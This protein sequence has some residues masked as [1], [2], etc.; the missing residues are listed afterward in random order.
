MSPR[1]MKKVGSCQQFIPS[2]CSMDDISYSKLS[3]QEVHKIAILDIRILN[4]DRNAANLLCRRKPEQPDT[5]ELIP[6]DH[7]YCLRTA[8]DICSFDWCWLDWPQLKQ[9][10]SQKTKEYILNLDI[11]KD[12]RMLKE[13]LEIPNGALDY[14]RASNQLLQN[15][16]KAGKTLYEIA[17]L[18]CR[19]DHLGERPSKLES[20]LSTAADIA[21]SAV[22]NGR[23]HHA[24]ASRALEQQLTPNNG[25]LA[26]RSF[27]KGVNGNIGRRNSTSMSIFKSASSVNFTSFVSS[28][29]ET[30]TLP[31]SSYDE[32]ELNSSFIDNNNDD[33][34]KIPIP[35]AQFSGSDS[36]SDGDGVVDEKEEEEECEQ[37]AADFIAGKL[38]EATTPISIPNMTRRQRSMSFARSDSTDSDD[39]SQLSKSPV[40]FWCVPPSASRGRDSLLEDTAV[41][42]PHVSP[43]SSHRNIDMEG[44]DLGRDRAVTFNSP[45]IPPSRLGIGLSSLSIGGQTDSRHICESDDED[46]EIILHFKNKKEVPESPLPPPPSGMMKRSQSYS[47]FSFKRITDSSRCDSNAARASPITTSSEEYEMYYQKYIKLLIDLE[48][49][50]TINSRGS[51]Q[52]TS[53]LMS[54]SSDMSLGFHLINEQ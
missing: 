47:A 23:W 9:P 34:N 25:Y 40:G 42:S 49:A 22:D 13:R 30:S 4:A 3:T 46:E 6:I 41:W 31:R 43:N 54:S 39:S 50:P 17:T 16:V 14:F 21:K 10:I 8:A 15:G 35:L 32:V 28:A 52:N 7:G 37:W 24:A 33:H 48:T 38:F 53:T 45:I 20:I 19:T 12:V 36:S 1:Q 44:L 5:F 18:C 11:E 26:T 51:S 29:T 2:E 27:S